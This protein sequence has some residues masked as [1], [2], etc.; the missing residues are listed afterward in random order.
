MGPDGSIAPLVLVGVAEAVHPA[1]LASESDVPGDGDCFERF[2]T[3]AVAPTA[4]ID[5]FAARFC[6]KLTVVHASMGEEAFRVN[7]D[8][9]EPAVFFA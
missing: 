2:Y 4:H 1:R 8:P 6:V 9:L 7:S 5:T 3:G